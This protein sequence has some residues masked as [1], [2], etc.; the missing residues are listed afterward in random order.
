MELDDAG[1]LVA[2]A[3]SYS[4]PSPSSVSKGP[5]AV[6]CHVYISS[7]SASGAVIVCNPPLSH[8][9]RFLNLDI[10][11]QGAFDS[12]VRRDLADD[13]T[14]NSGFLLLILSI[15]VF[16]SV[17][18]ALF[19]VGF[20]GHCGRYLIRVIQTMLRSITGRAPVRPLSPLKSAADCPPSIAGSPSIRS[21]IASSIASSY[22]S[23]PFDDGTRMISAANMVT[24]PV[25]VYSGSPSMASNSWMSF[26]SSTSPVP[27][28]SQL[29]PS[30]KTDPS[31]RISRFIS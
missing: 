2:D 9:R 31:T 22:V 16:A 13:S 26:G 29:P 8:F 25:R 21:S 15:A 14:S 27:R 18:V 19:H 23:S 28:Y 20:L 30:F 3:S 6:S 5:G 7:S 10:A 1:L 4:S 17:S 12:L 11:E 24:I